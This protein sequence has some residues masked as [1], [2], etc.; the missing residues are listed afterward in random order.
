[1]KVRYTELSGASGSIGGVTAARNR[2]GNYRRVRVAPLN[3]QSV[4]QTAVRAALAALSTSWR[5]A[6]S[7]QQRTD[8]E[9]YADTVVS[10]DSLGQNVK[11]TGLNAYVAGNSLRLQ[12]GQAVVNNAP[13]S[14][15]SPVFT[16]PGA[17][18]LSAT[19][20][21]LNVSLGFNITVGDSFN[22]AAGGA[23]H[24]Y[25]SEA[26]TE[27]IRYYKGPFRYWGSKIRGATAL[28]VAQTLAGPAPF[29]VIGDSGKF[30]YI[31]FV[32][33]DAQGRK[34]GEYI[35]RVSPEAP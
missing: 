22:L 27:S 8:W 11:L 33:T 10:T 32:T 25:I 28:A 2:G 26:V 20:G 18:S 1:M 23:I 7:P 31:K 6:L 14:T 12:A 3:P 34:S 29:P 16:L 30:H 35:I 13:N 4:F 5:D 9:T 15:G 17:T 24:V 19:G 21:G